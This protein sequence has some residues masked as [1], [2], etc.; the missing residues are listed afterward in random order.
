[1]SLYHLLR[2]V[3]KLPRPPEIWGKGV[4]DRWDFYSGWLYSKYIFGIGSGEIYSF[5]N[6][7]QTSLLIY[8]A[9]QSPFWSITISVGGI[10]GLFVLG[11]VLTTIGYVKKTNSLAQS[12]NEQLMEILENTRKLLGRDVNIDKEK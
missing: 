12:Q 7:V 10:V 5:W 8:V 1:M 4:E 2:T 6:V 9:F 11:H 3:I